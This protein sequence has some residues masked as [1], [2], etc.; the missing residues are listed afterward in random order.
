MVDSW[1]SYCQ[2]ALKWALLDYMNDKSALIPTEYHLIPIVAQF[3]GDLIE[4]ISYSYVM[5]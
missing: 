2:I 4:S 1:G 3:S 5:L